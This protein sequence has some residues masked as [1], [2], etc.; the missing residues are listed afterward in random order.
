MIALVAVLRE[1]G[2]QFAHGGRVRGAEVGGD[3]LLKPLG[4]GHLDVQPQAAAEERRRR[5]R[6]PLLVRMTT[7]KASH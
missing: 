4:V 7:G 6:S 2:N 5:F 3:D 1:L